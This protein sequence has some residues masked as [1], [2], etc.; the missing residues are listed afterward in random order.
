MNFNA[1]ALAGVSEKFIKMF[2]QLFVLTV[3]SRSLSPD[4][5]GSIL[6][7]LAISIIFIFLNKAGLESISS[8][9]FTNN[10]KA[11]TNLKHIL[12]IRYA[13]AIACLLLTLLVGLVLVP[14]E[15]YLLVIIFAFLHLLIPM[16]TYEVFYQSR[17]QGYI[18]AICLTLGHLIGLALAVYAWN[19]SEGVTFFAFVFIAPYIVTFA[20]FLGF[21][22]CSNNRP[23]G[24]FSYPIAKTIAKSGTPLLFSSAAVILYMKLDQ[25]MLGYLSGNAEVSIY[26]TATRLSEAWYV[27][28]ASLIAAYFPKLIITHKA[29][30][31]SLYRK[32]ILHK[33]SLLIAASYVLIAITL[34]FSEFIVTLFFGANYYSS[35]NVLN[36]TIMCVPLVYLGLLSTHMVII[37][38][39]LNQI[40]YRSIGGLVVNIILNLV[41]IPSYG[42]IG[43]AVATLAAQFFSALL[44]NFFSNK[45]IFRLQMKIITLRSLWPT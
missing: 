33:M 45:T 23:S 10:D 26:V 44:F 42:A 5:L 43:A 1:S 6:Y 18:G 7:C 31:R 40:I 34:L 9:F 30:S 41:L 15:H 36:I 38:G 29:G 13:C 37:E 2:S 8:K 24:R 39:S 28:G 21:S 16:N 14:E 3:A 25:I 17:A 27:L 19:T 11:T 35:S 22:L 32:E 4:E 20:A 12:F